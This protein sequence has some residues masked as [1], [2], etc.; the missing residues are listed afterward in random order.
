MTAVRFTVTPSAVGTLVIGA[1]ER[2][3]CCVLFAEE[4]AD[5]AA[6]VSAELPGA[7]AVRDDAALAP[8]LPAVLAAV[9]GSASAAEIPLDAVGT[10]FQKQVWAELARIPRGETATYTQIARRIG[11][12][13]ATRA[14]ANACGANHFAV[15]IPCHRVIRADG[16]LGG[17]RGGLERKRSLLRAEGAAL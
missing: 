6:L 16:S 14:V 3:I 10:P 15:L 8:Y 13:A 5:A 9:D 12:P 7:T 4:G 1:T 17:Y 11:R 2:G